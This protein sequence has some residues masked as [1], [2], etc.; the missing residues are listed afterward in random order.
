MNFPKGLYCFF[1]NHLLPFLLYPVFL[2]GIEI[3]LLVGIFKPLEH[4]PNEKHFGLLGLL[5][6]PEHLSLDPLVL[7]IMHIQQLVYVLSV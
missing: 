7:L 5:D 3:L 1:K 4:E 6:G 2:P